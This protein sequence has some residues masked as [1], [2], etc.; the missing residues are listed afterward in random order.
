MS[1]IADTKQPAKTA[2]QNVTNHLPAPS[3]TA[4]AAATQLKPAPVAAVA[5]VVPTPCAVLSKTTDKYLKEELLKHGLQATQQPGVPVTQCNAWSKFLKGFDFRD[6]SQGAWN[7]GWWQER[8]FV[9]TSRRS[10]WLY[11]GEM[12]DRKVNSLES[13]LCNG[14]NDVQMVMSMSSPSIPLYHR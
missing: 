5:V 12:N 10:S 3:K 8:R 6:G 4:T 2:L 1:T 14:P 13:W 11:D 9:G 7:E